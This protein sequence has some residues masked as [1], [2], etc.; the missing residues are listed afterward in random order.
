MKKFPVQSDDER[1][2]MAWAAS[3]MIS[4]VRLILAMPSP[5]SKL[6]T[7]AVSI[8]VSGHNELTPIASFLNSAAIPNVHIDMPYFAI[9]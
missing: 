1:V 2:R 6:R 8:A 9:V 4:G 3:A 7:A 5:P